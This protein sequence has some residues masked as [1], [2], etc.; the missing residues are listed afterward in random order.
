MASNFHKKE[1]EIV[2][3]K[4]EKCDGNFSRK[5]EKISFGGEFLVK[6]L[7]KSDS[8][9]LESQKMNDQLASTFVKTI[10]DYNKLE[11]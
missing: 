7:Q 3:L 8:E 1:L 6:I 11:N 4:S 2:S 10:G 9:K 5:K